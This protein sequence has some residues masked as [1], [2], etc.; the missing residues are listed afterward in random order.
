MNCYKI[1]IENVISDRTFIEDFMKNLI[2]DQH[3]IENFIRNKIFI[4]NKIRKGNSYIQVLEK[5]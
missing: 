5:S 3:F 1:C 2:S 4:K